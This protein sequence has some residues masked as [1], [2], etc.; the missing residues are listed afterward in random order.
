MPSDKKTFN[1]SNNDLKLLEMENLSSAEL[2]TAFGTSTGVF[3]VGDVTFQN[4]LTGE[5][6]TEPVRFQGIG[7]IDR[8]SVPHAFLQAAIGVSA[9]TEI[10]LRAMPR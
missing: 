7:G 9:G 2:P 1:L 8:S 4:P 3:F 10:T 6:L 5:I